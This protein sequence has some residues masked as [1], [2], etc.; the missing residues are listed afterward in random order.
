MFKRVCIFYTVRTV[1][2]FECVRLYVSH[3]FM[4][5]IWMRKTHER[6]SY[7]DKI[8]KTCCPGDFENARSGEVGHFVSVL[9]VPLILLTGKK[10]LNICECKLGSHRIFKFAMV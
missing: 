5:V 8:G 2:Y 1:L 6:N 10:C 7:T 9:Q 4:Y 3:G